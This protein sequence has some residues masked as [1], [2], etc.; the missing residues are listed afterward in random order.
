MED[1]Y[2]PDSFEEVIGMAM[3]DVTRERGKER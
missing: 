1:Y 2:L 3:D